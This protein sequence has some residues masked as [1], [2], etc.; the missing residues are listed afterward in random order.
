MKRNMQTPSVFTVVRV[1]CLFKD[2]L[3]KMTNNCRTEFLASFCPKDN[4][5]LKGAPERCS[6]YIVVFLKT[7][8]SKQNQNPKTN[9]QTQQKPKHTHK[10]RKA[11]FSR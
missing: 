4:V 9:K 11:L 1:K 5:A 3:N 8:T 7:K 10:K 2:R 6:K